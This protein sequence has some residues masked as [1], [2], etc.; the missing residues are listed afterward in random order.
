MDCQDGFMG[1]WD[2]VDIGVPMNFCFMRI[3]SEGRL[4]FIRVH[5]K[6]ITIMVAA[7]T[8]LAMKIFQS[9]TCSKCSFEGMSCI[10]IIN[11]NMVKLNPPPIEYVMQFLVSGHSHYKIM[12]CIIQWRSIMMLSKCLPSVFFAENTS[13]SDIAL[14][15]PGHQSV[16]LKLRNHQRS[17]PTELVTVCYYIGQ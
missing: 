17:T 10:I 8:T 12:R 6:F 11:V 14:V 1:S 9:G 13:W 4:K 5:K 3:A 15:K 16:L 2:E 7:V